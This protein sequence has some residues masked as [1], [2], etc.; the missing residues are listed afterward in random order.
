MITGPPATGRLPGDTR[1][2]APWLSARA[3]HDHRTYVLSTPHE[4]ERDE[5]VATIRASPPARVNWFSIAEI[6]VLAGTAGAGVM[7]PP[8]STRISARKCVGST[9]HP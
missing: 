6:L 9:V 7:E 3:R 1:A 8:T 2:H 4:E 5:W